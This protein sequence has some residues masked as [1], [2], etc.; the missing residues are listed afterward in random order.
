MKRFLILLS[1]LI[2]S[3]LADDALSRAIED[4]SANIVFMRHAMAPG[5]GDP[6]DFSLEDCAKQRNLD[7]QGIA[8]AQ[9]IGRAIEKAGIR[10]D[11]ILSS[12]WC[13]CRDTAENL[14]IGEWQEFAGLNSFYQFADKD[15]TMARLTKKLQTIASDEL[16][17]MVTHQV[18]ISEVTGIVPPSGGLVLY[19]TKTQQSHPLPLKW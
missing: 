6:P 17:L 2:P 18:V 7:A 1:L 15:S 10:F 13:R 14:G 19:N 11:E 3:A 9:G 12:Q 5:F 8:Q 4:I 16:I